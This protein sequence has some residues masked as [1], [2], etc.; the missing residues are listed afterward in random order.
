VV[1]QSELEHWRLE[2]A[3]ELARAVQARDA[4]EEHRRMVARRFAR[5]DSVVEARPNESPEAYRRRRLRV[6]ADLGLTANGSMPR[7]PGGQGRPA[8]RG[9]APRVAAPA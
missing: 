7:R 9:E 1:A 8:A 6:A 5:L 3:R 4:P 2:F